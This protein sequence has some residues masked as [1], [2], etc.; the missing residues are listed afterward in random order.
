MKF[1][2]KRNEF[3]KAV[4]TASRFI[5]T[6][7]PNPILLD[8]AL[9]LNEEG[10]ILYG[11]NGD[12]YL[13]VVVPFIIDGKEVIRDYKEGSVLINAKILNEI[14]KAIDG[15]EINFEI[16]EEGLAKL[17]NDS[18][19]KYSLTVTRFEEYPDCN[20]E[21]NG[22]RVILDSKLFQQAVNQVAFAASQKNTRQQL[23]A[24]NFENNG[25]NL[26]FTATD[27]SRLAKKEL[28]SDCANMFS[29]NIDAKTLLEAARTI[30][31]EKEIEIYASDKKVLFKYVN[32]KIITNLIGGDYP[33]VKNII[34]KTYYYFLEVNAND[35]LNA[36]NSVAMLTLDREN[37]VKVTMVEGNVVVSS[38]SQLS[39]SGE[40]ILS[41]FRY[42][43]ERLEI[44]FNYH[45]VVDAIKALG[46]Q[47]VLLSFIGEMK[48]FTIT[49]K[50]DPSNIHLITPVR[51]Y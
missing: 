15:E 3:L 17:E 48:P 16:V 20:F 40:K 4:T 31:N 45:F 36:I 22:T 9:V 43:G 34:P 24:V 8:V 46:S 39:G 1:N 2:I 6:S 41:L 33:N 12:V 18:N 27:G 14:V 21:E 26:I 23:K 51:T 7:S 11:G 47:D 30:E 29:I 42:T 10:L 50:N 32:T 28:P 5:P 13:E 49:D 35:F 25:T 19:T 37:I 38:K 44:S